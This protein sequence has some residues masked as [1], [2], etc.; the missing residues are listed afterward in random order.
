MFG[1]HVTPDIEA[2][3]INLRDSV[4]CA[5]SNPFKVEIIGKGGHGAHPES[6]VDPIVTT[7]NIVST[8][9]QIISREI[10]PLNPGVLTVGKI[11]GGNVGNV[12][13]EKVSFEGMIRTMTKEDR[14]HVKQRFIEIVNNIARTMRC[15]AKIHIED[16]YPCLYN[17]KKIVNVLEESAKDIIGEKNIN[18]PQN[19]SMVVESFAYFAQE[20]PSVFYFLGV[21]NKEKGI[22]APLHNPKFDV[23]ESGLVYGVALQCDAAIRFLNQ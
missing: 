10:S 8:L 4:V 19:P 18:H 15:E 11:S 7:C 14:A 9:Q 2:G 22:T 5:A 1:L 13:P 20:V 21:G 6:T 12:I 3:E 17:D 23:D 16:G